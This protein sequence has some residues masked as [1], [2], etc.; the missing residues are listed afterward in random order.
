MK[1]G[2]KCKTPCKH[3]GVV[4]WVSE[5]GKTVAV[6]CMEVHERVIKK[7]VGDFRVRFKPVYLMEVSVIERGVS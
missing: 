1:V 7:P 6:Q 2:D 4:V 5:D 3:K